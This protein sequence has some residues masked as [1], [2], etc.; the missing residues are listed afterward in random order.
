M[1]VQM[2]WGVRGVGQAGATFPDVDAACEALRSSHRRSLRLITPSLESHQVT[3]A[4]REVIARMDTE[5]RVR[6]AAGERWETAFGPVWITL[7]PHTA[8]SPPSV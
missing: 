3:D 2:N 8:E 4:Y 7:S 6:V 1:A 5:G